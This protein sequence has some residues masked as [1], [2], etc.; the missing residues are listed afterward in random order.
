MSEKTIEA[1]GKF[2]FKDSRG[3]A[4]M[5]REDLKATVPGQLKSW[6]SILPEK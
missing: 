2:N 6:G 5:Q 3:I 1:T 4:Q